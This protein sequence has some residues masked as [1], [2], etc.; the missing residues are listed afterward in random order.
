MTDDPIYSVTIEE[1]ILDYLQDWTTDSTSGTVEG[2]QL[3]NNLTISSAEVERFYKKGLSN[4]KSFM[5]RD[6]CPDDSRIMEA[7]CKWTAG[8]LYKK[9]NIRAGD[10]HEDEQ[11]QVGYGDSLIISAKNDLEPYRVSYVKVW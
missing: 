6:Y 3:N 9:Y 1:N 7:V 2:L 4:C 10:N 11:M 8:L 5:C